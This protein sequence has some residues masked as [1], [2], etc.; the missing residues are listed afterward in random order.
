MKLQDQSLFRQQCYI[1][2]AWADADDLALEEHLVHGG[3]AEEESRLSLA[4]G[5]RAPRAVIHQEERVDSVF[6][7][8]PRT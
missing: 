1:D 6:Q 7:R 4:A 8:Q 5:N 3:E 2:G